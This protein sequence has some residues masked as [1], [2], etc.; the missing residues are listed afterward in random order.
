MNDV[1]KLLI[2]YMQEQKL[3]QLATLSNGSPW[4]CSVWYSFDDDLN[5]YFFSAINRQHSI[6]I[7]KYSHVAG[8]IVKVHDVTDKPRGIQFK[9]TAVKITES[10]DAEQARSVYQDRIFDAE[11]IDKLTTHPQRPHAFYKISVAKYVLFDTINFP[12]QPMQ[13]YEP[14]NKL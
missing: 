3:M 1:K 14:E 7:E 12:D 2:E 13:E 10:S 8:A 5:I 9:G 6:D 11:T 4:V